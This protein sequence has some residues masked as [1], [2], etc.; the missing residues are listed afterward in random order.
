MT[1]AATILPALTSQ[2]SNNLSINPR[3]DFLSSLLSSIRP[4]TP[5]PSLLATIKQRLLS[6]PI[7]ASLLATPSNIFPLD[8]HH[9]ESSNLVPP[10]ERRVAGPIAVQV[11]RYEDVSRSRWEQLEEIEARL[12]GE[13][14]RG[15]AVVRV[16]EDEG[17]DE[18]GQLARPQGRSRDDAVWKIE[19]EDAA[20]VRI[21]GIVM[22]RV[23]GLG[24]G[25]AIGLKMVLR[26]IIVARGVVL[27]D[28]TCVTV[29]GGKIEAMHLAW[30]EN[31]KRELLAVLGVD[32]AGIPGA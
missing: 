26:N 14:R 20:G 6:A 19:L 8:I 13:G 24:A 10:A 30:E 27:L 28:P 3:P 2:L 12:R 23:E 9:G 22:K 7:T 29:L 32:E 15:W 21:W 25:M 1:H 31:R 4:T 17:Q 18:D 5:F 16:G 11:V